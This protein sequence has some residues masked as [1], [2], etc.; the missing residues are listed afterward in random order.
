MDRRER[1]ADP[2][3][4][5]LAAILGHQA[6]LWT[7]L[8]AIVLS[9]D[10][11]KGTCELQPAIRGR[12]RLEDG[13]IQSVT[14]P[15]LVDCPVVFPGGGGHTLTFPIKAGD[16]ALVVFASRCIDGWWDT[17]GVQPPA[18]LRMH[19]LS[20]GFAIIGPR[21]R[22]KALTA[23][24][25]DGVELR[26]DA[27]TTFVRLDDTGNVFIQTDANV[28]VDA[29]GDVYA[30]SGGD[31]VI[32]AAGSLHL[33]APV[34]TIVGDVNVTGTLSNNGHAVGST[35]THALPGASSSLTGAPS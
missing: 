35:H 26:N 19:D 23:A 1:S 5:I 30:S 12:F 20:D 22:P 31:A 2:D 27:R 3:T 16:E 14:M 10:P 21:S 8:P 24:S 33:T 25:T 28:S 32:T 17:S 11:S 9:Y 34:I 13:A 15:P 29:Q 6:G 4:A 7:A 18:E